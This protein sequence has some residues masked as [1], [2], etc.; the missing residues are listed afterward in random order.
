M[1]LLFDGGGAGAVILLFDVLAICDN[2]STL[3]YPIL[4]PVYTIQ[5]EPSVRLWREK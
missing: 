4:L 2:R 1:I 3:I 5:A